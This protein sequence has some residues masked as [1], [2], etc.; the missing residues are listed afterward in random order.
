MIRAW[1]SAGNLIIGLTREM[2]LKMQRTDRCAI[3]EPQDASDSG[4]VVRI[5]IA[6]TDE[7]VVAKM[8]RDYGGRDPETVIDNRKGRQPS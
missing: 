7:E 3:S 4:V 1:D 6:D 2:V 5:Y 8:T